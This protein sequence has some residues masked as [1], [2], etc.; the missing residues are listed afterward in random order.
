MARLVSREID[1][2]F[3]VLR[4]IRQGHTDVREYRRMPRVIE[5]VYVRGLGI[6]LR[7]IPAVDA[8]GEP[9]E[10]GEVCE[11]TGLVEPGVLTGFPAG[12][13]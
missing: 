6:S 4:P 8:D 7:R 1:D 11:I 10:G 5:S 2:L 9:G 12:P 3:G 13:G